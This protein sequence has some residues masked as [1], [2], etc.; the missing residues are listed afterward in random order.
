[1]TRTTVQARDSSLADLIG[2]GD[3]VFLTRPAARLYVR[4]AGEDSNTFAG[5]IDNCFGLFPNLTAG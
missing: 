1:V 4:A 2:P 3:K 5:A